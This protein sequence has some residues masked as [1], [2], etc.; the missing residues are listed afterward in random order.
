[1][2]EQYQIS[3]M[4]LCEE[5]IVGNLVRTP[6]NTWSNLAFFLI[7]FWLLFKHKNSL[8]K[9]PL[10][11][12]IVVGAFVVGICSFIYHMSYIKGFLILDNVGMFLLSSF[13]I[14]L[15]LKRFFNFKIIYFWIFY[16]LIFS[17]STLIAFSSYFLL[18]F[19]WFFVLYCLA[20]ILEL[21][22]KKYKKDIN[23]YRYFIIMLSLQLLGGVFWIIDKYKIICNPT[24]HWF[25][26]H[27]IWHFANAFVIYFLFKHFENYFTII[28]KRK[29]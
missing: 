24:N 15:D 1:M 17:I 8:K 21:F 10:L 25:Q 16:F 7:V 3:P 29:V 5:P 28:K 20:I 26:V 27:M 4:N 11:Y 22:F 12:I 2:W 23:N 9:Y 18:G 6:A 14:A 19:I 13:V